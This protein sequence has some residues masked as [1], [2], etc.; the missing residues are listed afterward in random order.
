MEFVDVNCYAKRRWTPV[1]C[2]LLNLKF[3][4]Y[5]QWLNIF[6][7]LNHRN[8]LFKLLVVVKQ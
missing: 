6:N 8:F 4:N 2:E 3:G 7:Q 1:G 5:I